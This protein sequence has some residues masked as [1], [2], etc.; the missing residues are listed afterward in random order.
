MPF[1]IALC[2]LVSVTFNV[3]NHFTIEVL[4]L[5]GPIKRGSWSMSDRLESILL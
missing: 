4:K 2:D 3:M 1:D 5:K